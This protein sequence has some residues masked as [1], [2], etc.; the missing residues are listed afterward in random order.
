TTSTSAPAWRRCATA[1]E[2]KRPAKSSSCR[3]YEVVKTATRRSRPETMAGKSAS[4]RARLRAMTPAGAGRAPAAPGDAL[5]SEERQ[6]GGAVR[7]D[8]AHRRL[9][10]HD[11]VPAPHLREARHP[12]PRGGS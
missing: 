6:R 11:E 8:H 1:S 5:P 2:T 3:G 10:G 7:K 12:S 9:V 4:S